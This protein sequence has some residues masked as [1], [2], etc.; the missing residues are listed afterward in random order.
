MNDSPARHDTSSYLNDLDL[1]AF[2][3]SELLSKE[4]MYIQKKAP[5]G[6]ID[7]RRGSK[8]GE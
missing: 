2:S 8:S 6:D 4:G 7:N 1:P 3:P 5:A